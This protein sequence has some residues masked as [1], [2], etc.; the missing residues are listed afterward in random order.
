MAATRTR[1]RGHVIEPAIYSA[2]SENV[3]S[4]ATA[5]PHAGGRGGS[6]FTLTSVPQTHSR[7]CQIRVRSRRRT[8]TTAATRQMP[9]W[10][11]RWRLTIHDPL[12]PPLD[13]ICK[14]GVAGSS[15]ARSIAWN[16]CKSP[17]GRRLAV[18]PRGNNSDD[19]VVVDR[20]RLRVVR[21]VRPEESLLGD[22]DV[23]WGT[24]RSIILIKSESLEP[25]PVFGRCIPA[26]IG[27]DTDISAD[28]ATHTADGVVVLFGGTCGGGNLSL[29][30]YTS[31]RLSQ[32]DLALTLDTA[33]PVAIAVD[34]HR[35]RVLLISSRHA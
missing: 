2:Y 33:T 28:V 24:G 5:P 29:S 27:G 26:V 11:V 20:L 12:R 18:V 14:L 19:L 4:M 32:D 16:P 31:D 17:D 13:R 30:P 8:L 9:G 1:N 22:W 25:G 23:A 35:H 3:T 10:P 15:P 34:A 21:T 6:G 7:A